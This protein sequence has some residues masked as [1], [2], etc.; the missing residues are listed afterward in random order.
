MQ[1]RC[2][3]VQIVTNGRRNVRYRD[4]QPLAVAVIEGLKERGTALVRTIE[5]A[6][7]CARLRGVPQKADQVRQGFLEAFPASAV[8][9]WVCLAR[10]LEGLH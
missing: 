5:H 2:C 6:G 8:L 3:F 4:G 9:T 1:D 7:K 10:R